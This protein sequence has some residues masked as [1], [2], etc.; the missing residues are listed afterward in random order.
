M[1][2]RLVNALLLNVILHACNHFTAGF[3][4]LSESETAS[5]R[6]RLQH[7]IKKP[8]ADASGLNNMINESI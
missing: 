7:P 8:P 1:R 2:G 5:V 4:S 3:D 6:G